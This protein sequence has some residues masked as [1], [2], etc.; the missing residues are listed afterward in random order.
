MGADSLGY[1]PAEKL[2][3]LAGHSGICKACFTGK[4]PTSVPSEAHK[5]KYEMKIKEN[6]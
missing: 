3:V 2:A 6:G 1:L 4:Y 5:D